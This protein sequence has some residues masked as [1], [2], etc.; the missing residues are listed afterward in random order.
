L[1]GDSQSTE[2]QEELPATD[3]LNSLTIEIPL[4]GFDPA[5]LD[6]L[7]KLVNAK[8]E[9]I[10]AALGV[11]EIP[12]RINGGTVQ[13]PWFRK[14]S[15]TITAEEVEAYSAF[16]S[17]LCKTARNKKRITAKAKELDG[18][19]KFAMRCFLLSIGMIGDEYKISRRVLL[20]KLDGS[21]SWKYKGIKQDEAESPSALPA[22]EEHK[23]ER[24]LMLE[25][26]PPGASILRAYTA[27]ENGELRVITN[28]DGEKRYVVNYEDGYPRLVHK[29]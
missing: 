8:E 12:I 23:S 7:F 3:E 17:L 1:P 21:S 11:R 22:E 13:F 2:T 20:S 28:E 15:T 4:D 9:L 26:L 24:E 5:K 29:P 14:K 6:N 10:K 27:V 25:Q 18:S 16:I 19:P